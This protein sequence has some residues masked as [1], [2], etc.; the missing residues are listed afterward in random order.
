MVYY[1]SLQRY[2][3]SLH[4][5]ELKE[6]QINETQTLWLYDNHRE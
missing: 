6:G 2:K 1:N 4:Q 5:I 3:T